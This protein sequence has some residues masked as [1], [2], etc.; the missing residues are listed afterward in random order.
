MNNAEIKMLKLLRKNARE[1]LT[2]I[3]R[4]TGIPTSTV[5]MKLADQEKS[6]I[7]KHTSLLNFQNLGYNYWSK[8]AVKLK[9]EN[10]DFE[11]YLMEHES[12]NSVY[13]INSGFNYLVE[14]I[15]R[16]IKQYSD[17]MRELES[18]F[19]I[20]E[21]KEFQIIEDLKREDFLSIKYD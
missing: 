16:N 18:K 11:K 13:E 12:V 2:S 15:H 4:K 21:K 8:F 17:F 14:T 1:S 6:V 3:S 9:E 19:D 10:S 20:E 5:F 7:T